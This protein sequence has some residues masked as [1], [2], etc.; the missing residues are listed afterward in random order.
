[1]GDS[2]PSASADERA[3]ATGCSRPPVAAQ[4]MLRCE[5]GAPEVRGLKPR[6]DGLLVHSFWTSRPVGGVSGRSDLRSG[7]ETG[8]AS[9]EARFKGALGTRSPDRPPTV[10]M[11]K[12]DKGRLPRL[13]KSERPA[14]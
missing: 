5:S 1:M 7:T 8:G 10:F 14:R 3:V 13:A 4:G 11:L 12:E 2:A 9:A 6:R